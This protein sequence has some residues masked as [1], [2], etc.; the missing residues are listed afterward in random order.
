MNLTGISSFFK[1]KTQER[2]KNPVF[3]RGPK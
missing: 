2:G 3:R 1:G